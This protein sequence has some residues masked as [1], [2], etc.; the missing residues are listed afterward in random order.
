MTTQPP[1]ATAR[2][3]DKKTEIGFVKALWLRF[4][5]FLNYHRIDKG[6][7]AV[8]AIFCGMMLVTLVIREKPPVFQIEEGNPWPVMLKNGERHQ[9]YYRSPSGD[10]I[11]P[12][13]W[14]YLKNG[15]FVWLDF[16]GASR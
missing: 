3:F 15:Q 10:D 8:V 5:D 2:P 7:A 9:L 16:D 14:C 12:K 11:G 6:L 1:A 4:G 13:Q